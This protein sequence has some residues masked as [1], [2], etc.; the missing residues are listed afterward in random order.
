MIR[1]FRRSSSLRPSLAICLVALV[2]LGTI[3]WWHA[4][5]AEAFTLPISHDHAEHQAIIRTHEA[6]GPAEGEHC[7]LCHWLRTLQN[8][9][10]TVSLHGLA[11]AESRHV[12]L[13]SIFDTCDP[14]ASLVPARAP[15]V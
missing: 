11:S 13:T 4:S 15:P 7:Y 8:G 3:D 10:D 12:Q 5:D 6:S 9:L 14:V 1:R 2:L